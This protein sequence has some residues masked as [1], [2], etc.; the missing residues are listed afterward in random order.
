MTSMCEMQIQE[1]LLTRLDCAGL[2]WTVL[3]WTVLD[4]AR[5]VGLD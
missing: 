4:C 5:P 2:D 1:V 3:D